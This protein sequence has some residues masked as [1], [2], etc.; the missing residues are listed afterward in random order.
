M[1]AARNDHGQAE[2]VVGKSP[3]AGEGVTKVTWTLKEGHLLRPD[4]QV[5]AVALRS[6]VHVPPMVLTEI[7]G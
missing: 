3:E 2:E 5:E 4:L 6:R 7:C 1:S